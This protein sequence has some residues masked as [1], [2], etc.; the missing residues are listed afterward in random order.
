MLEFSLLQQFLLVAKH[1]SLSRAAEEMHLSQPA[2]SRSMRRLEEELGT[3]LFFHKK[4]RIFL[5]DTGRLAASHAKKILRSI[6]GMKRQINLLNRQ[7]NTISI[8][9]CA[10]APLWDLEPLL[11][12]AFPEKT[13]ETSICADVPELLSAL[14]NGS[15]QLI[16]LTEPLHEPG[17]LCQQGERESLYFSFPKTHRFAQK[18]GVRLQEM[19]GENMLLFNPIGFWNELH[20]RTMPNSHFFVQSNRFEFSELVKKSEL[21]SFVTNLSMQKYGVPPGRCI[22]PVLD[23]EAAVTFYYICKEGDSFLLPS[24]LVRM[25]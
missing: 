22:V 14:K 15:C 17:L 5:S 4:N 20:A 12:K 19:D 6:D 10:P 3:K 24:S 23:E 18:Q 2:L 11:K 16:I 13:I 8:G 7:K 25:S 9:S 21:A 1:E